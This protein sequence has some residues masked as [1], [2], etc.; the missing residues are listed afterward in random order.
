MS[1]G[2]S[3]QHRLQPARAAAGPAHPAGRLHGEV[4]RGERGMGERLLGQLVVARPGDRG[5]LQRGLERLALPVQLRVAAA[6]RGRAPPAG[7]ARRPRLGRRARGL[8]HPAHHHRDVVPA[9]PA[10]QPA[11]VLV[12]QVLAPDPGDQR[13]RALQRGHPA[14]GAVQVVLAQH[15]ADGELE[16]RLAAGHQV[17]H[18]GVALAPGAARRGPGRPG[19]WPRTSARRSSGRPRTPSAPPP[20]RPRRRRRCRS[21]RPGRRS[22]RRSAG[23]SP[24]CARRR[25]RCRRRRPR[26]ARRPGAW[27]SRRC[28][29]RPRP[30]GG[31]WRSPVWPG[32]ARTAPWSCGR[33]RCRTVLRYL[34]SMPSSSNSRRAPKPT[35]S[36]PRSRIGQSSRRW[37][38]SIGPRRP[39]LVNPAL[40]SSSTE[41]PA[42]SRCLVRMS[43]PAGA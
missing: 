16:Q 8:P 5:D 4:H 6:G 27:P 36:P 22:R 23:G 13:H 39:S 15:R 34:A 2:H 41:N 14:L 42:A 40:I 33:R 10:G 38:R 29:P 28:S 12:A 25:T 37:N 20:A 35:T 30:P 1:G 31:A 26:S 32:R 19:R 3:R 17:A 18:R 24:R 43:Q 9:G 7:A 21:P 11:G